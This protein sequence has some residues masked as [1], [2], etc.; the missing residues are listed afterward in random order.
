MG[1]FAQLGHD[2]RFD[3]AAWMPV[4]FIDVSGEEIRARQE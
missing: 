4:A 2:Q 1:E 3:A